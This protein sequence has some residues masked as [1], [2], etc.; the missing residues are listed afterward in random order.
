[1][2]P[3]EVI[4]LINQRKDLDWLEIAGDYLPYITNLSYSFNVKTI[5]IANE[6]NKNHSIPLEW[7]FKFYSSVVPSGT[8]NTWIKGSKEKEVDLT[9][10]KLFYNVSQ[11]KAEEIEKILT[12]DQI[13]DIELKYNKN[14]GK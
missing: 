3:F 11:S 6:L 4:R 12:V 8:K 13:K 7:Q 2:T 5:M 10:I 9:W 1:M 14:K